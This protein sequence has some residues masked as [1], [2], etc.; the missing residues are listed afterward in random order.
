[1]R[2][3]NV[4]RMRKY[5]RTSVL[6]PEWVDCGYIVDDG[7]SGTG[8][9]WLAPPPPHSGVDECPGC[10]RLGR[11]YFTGVDLRP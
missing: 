7:L 1:M 11:R 8:V 2:R 10:A 4:R 5:L 9:Y 3:L 6:G